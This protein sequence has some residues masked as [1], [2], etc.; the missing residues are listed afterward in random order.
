MTEEQRCPCCAQDFST[1]PC[2]LDDVRLLRARCHTHGK[3]IYSEWHEALSLQGLPPADQ[4]AD[5]P[6]KRM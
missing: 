4:E 6:H 1:C 2:V 5:D 3:A